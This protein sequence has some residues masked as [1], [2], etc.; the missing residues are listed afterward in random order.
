MPVLDSTTPSRIT[1]KL[2]VGVYALL[3][4][5]FGL[6]VVFII[7]ISYIY[8]SQK[9]LLEAQIA[10]VEHADL[11]E[12]DSNKLLTDIT[13][14]S[15]TKSSKALD[16]L[17]RDIRFLNQ[18]LSTHISKLPQ[19]KSD[20]RQQ[21][22]ML[23]LIESSERPLSNAFADKKLYFKA[24]LDFERLVG[25]VFALNNEIQIGIELNILQTNLRF[26]GEGDRA[27]DKPLAS[28][29]QRTAYENRQRLGELELS[30]ARLRSLLSYLQEVSTIE[31]LMATE[32]DY[33]LLVRK[34]AS[35]AAELSREDVVPLKWSEQLYVSVNNTS[36]IFTAKRQVIDVD[37]SFEAALKELLFIYGEI[38][39]SA[40]KYR[41]QVVAAHAI[42]LTTLQRRTNIVFFFVIF[43][44]ILVVL[45]YSNFF[46]R[47]VYD[48]LIDPILSITQVT[49][50]LSHGDLSV[51][52]SDYSSQELM[53]MADALNVFRDNAIALNRT[54]IE[55]KNANK[56]IEDFAY[57]ASHDLK[58]PLR[59]II[60]L[61]SFLKQDLSEHLNEG[62]LEHL[63]NI[64]SRCCRLEN[65]LNDLLDYAHNTHIGSQVEDVDAHAF[66]NDIFVLI[67]VDEKFILNIK[68][69]VVRLNV[70]C[71]PLGQVLQNL[72][73]NAIKHHDK[74]SGHIN[75]TISVEKKYY[76]F[77]VQDDGPGIPTKY[78]K[79][80]FG[81]FQTLLPR[82]ECEGSGMGLAY[83]AKIVNNVGGEINIYSNP[84]VQR[85]ARFVFK[86]PRLEEITASS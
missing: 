4:V 35:I 21:K 77:Q 16:Y 78:H 44:L 15:I 19:N 74:Q 80:I 33:R 17:D 11:I 3:S 2:R 27:V 25:E 65:L 48:E 1:Q 47:L 41:E 66:V 9:L 5:T 61:V 70:L 84:D 58:S 81:L 24:V 50:R 13:K 40:T 12:L 34:F 62:C 83:V 59:G 39:K 64:N 86:W 82:D 45:A 60:H 20:E 76:I 75:V 51:R 42:E 73:D 53:E 85:G 37:D 52:A 32:N 30:R 26:Y 18:Q 8:F 10:E 79:R 54:N 22:R 67:N 28:V 29:S 68:S 56:D 38:E 6:L 14:L 63:N 57:A 72:M 46:R 43:M 7:G 49:K 36:T 23:D 31:M 71:I 55:L 69:D